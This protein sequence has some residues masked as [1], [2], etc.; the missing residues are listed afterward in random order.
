MAMIT[1]ARVSVFYFL[2]LVYIF[3]SVMVPSC[4]YIAVNEIEP[5][6]ITFTKIN[7]KWVKNLNVKP[8]MLK[9]LGL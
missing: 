9:L 4:F 7:S 6:P 8:E 1:S 2:P 3:V 5:I